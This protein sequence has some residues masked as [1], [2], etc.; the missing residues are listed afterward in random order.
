[1]NYPTNANILLLALEAEAKNT[2]PI[3]Q[4]YTAEQLREHPGDAQSAL[5]KLNGELSRFLRHWFCPEVPDGAF[6]FNVNTYAKNFG[7]TLMLNEGIYKQ[8]AFTCGDVKA[9]A[10]IQERSASLPMRRLILFAER[11]RS[12]CVSGRWNMLGN[13]SEVLKAAEQLRS[14][15]GDPLDVREASVA[16]QPQRTFLDGKCP[17]SEVSKMQLEQD[18]QGEKGI[19]SGT[20]VEASDSSEDDSAGYMFEPDCRAVMT[21]WGER[22]SFTSKQAEVMQELYRALLIGT[23]EVS[24]SRLISQV[25]GLHQKGKLKKLFDNDQAWNAMIE[26]GI[27]KGLIRLKKP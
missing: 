27:K 26:S 4:K 7:R 13:L 17:D 8:L 22:F 3:L 20:L 10:G 14:E 18:Q 1:M 24:Q 5:L 25:Y 6:D 2:Q 16:D 9:S 23:W 21:P 15:C 12:D 11:I 19:V